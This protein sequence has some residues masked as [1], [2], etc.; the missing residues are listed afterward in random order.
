MQADTI[1]SSTNDQIVRVKSHTT[2]ENLFPFGG[3]PEEEVFELNNAGIRHFYEIEAIT[4]PQ[5][6]KNFI[7]NVAI[8]ICGIAQIIVGVAFSYATAGLGAKLSASM[9]SEG[10]MDI[11]NAVKASINGQVLNFNDY[12]SDK[13]MNYA[14]AMIAA[15]VGS[16]QTDK[17]NQA[18]KQGS[19]EVVKK[20]TEEI[21]KETFKQKLID[22]GKDAV[23]TVIK[24]EAGLALARGISEALG[25]FRGGVKKNALSEVKRVLEQPHVEKMLSSIFAVDRFFENRIKQQALMKR[26]EEVLK[27][28]ERQLF[29]LGKKL[30]S[31]VSNHNTTLNIINTGVQTASYIQELDEFNNMLDEFCSDLEKIITEMYN[32]LPSTSKMISQKL[33][34]FEN[35]REVMDSRLKEAGII[36]G[37]RSFNQSLIGFMPMEFS[38]KTNTKV[39][40]GVNNSSLSQQIMLPKNSNIQPFNYPD[41]TKDPKETTPLE[42][43]NFGNNYIGGAKQIAIN[44]V[45]Q[46]NAAYIADYSQ[47]RARLGDILGQSISGNMMSTLQNGIIQPASGVV[48]RMGIDKLHSKL[49]EHNREVRNRLLR[50]TVRVVTLGEDGQLVTITGLSAGETLLKQ[51]EVEVDGEVRYMPRPH[52][53][54]LPLEINPYIEGKETNYILKVHYRTIGFSENEVTNEIKQST[55]P[56]HIYYELIDLNSF[57]SKFFSAYPVN[58]DGSHVGKVYN[59]MHSNSHLLDTF[60]HEQIIK[61]ISTTGKQVLFTKVLFLSQDQFKTTSE[62]ADTINKDRTYVLGGNDCADLGKELFQ[63]IDMPAE[64]N[65]LFNKKELSQ[66]LVGKK[67]KI[68]HGNRDTMETVMGISREEV[69]KKYKVKLERVVKKYPE[70]STS[71]STLN[72]TKDNFIRNMEY[73]ILPFKK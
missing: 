23:F 39:L 30:V 46:L 1:N 3:Y 18:I 64:Y 73:N 66:A 4:P 2:I 60:Q 41:L 36:D 67:I 21:T 17:A 48:A 43:I 68:M 69:A 47:E 10:I 63:K 6:P 59:P 37:E 38:Q 52:E 27:P 44:A 65:F 32:D 28:R 22:V 26:I 49:A 31:S 35:E 61:H 53:E 70:L 16:I 58:K 20:G 13:G 12:L 24:H 50:E 62:F 14:V 5:D 33:H 56:G 19:K 55:S 29:D 9:I 54:I 45:R 11:Y 8:A 57:K 40:E 15:G 51:Y 72:S 71:V 34:L 25:N 42:K 7:T